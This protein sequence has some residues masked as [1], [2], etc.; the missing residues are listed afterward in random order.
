MKADDCGFNYFPA[1]CETANSEIS[2]VS[3]L[4]TIARL[5]K[6]IQLISHFSTT[7]RPAKVIRVSGAR[8]QMEPRRSVLIKRLFEVLHFPQEPKLADPT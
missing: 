8:A 3:C 7:S 5:I 4:Q 6:L 1:A 2:N